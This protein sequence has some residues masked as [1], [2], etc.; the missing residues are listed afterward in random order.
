MEINMITPKTKEEARQQAIDYQTEVAEKDL[1][2]SEILIMG[3][4]FTKLA[5]KWDLSEEFKENGII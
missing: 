4:Y 1:S 2:Y 5:K 3:E